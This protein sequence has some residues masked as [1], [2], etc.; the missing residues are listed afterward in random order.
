LGAGASGGACAKLGVGYSTVAAKEDHVAMTELQPPR[1]IRSV[2]PKP[3]Y[4][5][6][7]AWERGPQTTVDMTDLIQKGGVF[8]ALR[9]EKVFMQVHLSENR[10]K[11][12]W[13]EPRDE[14]GEPIIDIDAES[15]FYIAT[16]QR[17][18]QL[19]NRLITTMRSIDRTKKS[20]DKSTD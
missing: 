5:L 8:E 15:L 19:F 10:R 4:R 7:I 14:D 16:E 3:G 9:N 2:E 12:E 1:F 13:P 11:I 17:S 18:N 20:L 6:A